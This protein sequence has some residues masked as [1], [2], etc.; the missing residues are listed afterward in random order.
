M[1]GYWGPLLI[2]GARL[3]APGEVRFAWG[4][5]QHL[6]SLYA[7]RGSGRQPNGSRFLP[8]LLLVREP[9][10]Y[11]LQADGSTFSTTVTIRVRG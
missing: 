6:R 9:G 11:G 7:Q 1:R 5:G 10:C 3:D 4:T 2:R 8:N